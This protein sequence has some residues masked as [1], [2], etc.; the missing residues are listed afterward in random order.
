MG[1]E[2]A[3]EERQSQSMVHLTCNSSVLVFAV[4]LTFHAPVHHV[5]KPSFLV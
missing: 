2:T 5:L 1:P 3:L 4:V